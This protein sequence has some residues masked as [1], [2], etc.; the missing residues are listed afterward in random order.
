[1]SA[2]GNISHFPDEFKFIRRQAFTTLRQPQESL[3][4]AD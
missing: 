2:D 3:E 4:D 1:M